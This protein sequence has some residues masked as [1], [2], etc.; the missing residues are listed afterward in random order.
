MSHV[1]DKN[2]IYSNADL[3][4]HTSLFEGLPNCI[5]EAINYG[6]PVIACKGVGATSEILGNGKYGK[7]L[8]KND[9]YEISKNIEIYLKNPKILQ[10]KIL[11]SKRIL[12]QFKDIKTAKTLEKEIIRIFN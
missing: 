7:I 11:K 3:L 4:I 6:V 9:K 12:Y 8:K 2:K 5:V 10:N 1:K